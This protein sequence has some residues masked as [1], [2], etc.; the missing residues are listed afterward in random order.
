VGD[1]NIVRQMLIL[2]FSSAT[3]ESD[4][5]EHYLTRQLPILVRNAFETRLPGAVIAAPFATKVGDRRVW[6]VQARS[7]GDDSALAFGSQRGFDF[8]VCGHLEP[9]DDAGVRIL[10][11]H[12]LDTESQSTAVR[13][14]VRGDTLGL[15]R[16]AIEALA[17]LLA[18]GA[19]EAGELFDPGTRS[20]R[21]YECYMQGLDVL[22]TLRSSDMALDD[23]AG[24]LDPFVRALE[25]D[26]DFADALTAGMSCALQAT[27]PEGKSLSFERIVAA[28]ARWVDCYP[29][30]SRIYAVWAELLIHRRLLTEALGVLERSHVRLSPVPRELVRRA[31]D[32]LVDLARHGE[33]LEIYR[34]CEEMQ[35]DKLVRERMATLC[36]ML[37]RADEARVHL[38]RCLVDEPDRT[39]LLT[40]LALMELRAGDERAM[41]AHFARVFRTPMGPSEADLVKLNSVLVQRPAADE[42]RDALRS[43]F[44][45]ASFARSS[46]I[47]LARALRLA[48]ARTESNLCLKSIA[49]DGLAP[50]LRSSLARERLN[51]AYPDFDREFGELAKTVTEGRADVDRQLLERAAAAEPDFWPARFVAAL[52]DARGGRIE[53]AVDRFAEVIELQPKND[54]VWYTRGL[55]LLKLERFV[56]AV[57]HFQRAVA[58]NAADG[59]YHI[60]LALA[61]AH[62]RLPEEARAS[63]ARAVALRPDHPDN[64]RLTRDIE[65]ALRRFAHGAHEEL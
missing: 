40:K 8:V 58:L 20:A 59:D 50:E 23:A 65:R 44:P 28:L 2:P 57:E 19:Q 32:V 6:V 5:S 36:V 21:A 15:G 43:W 47:V 31:G 39:D 42:L 9:T 11:L 18:L 3:A 12:A 4:P 37:Q 56:E 22:L 55:Y 64:A 33:A 29:G 25:T 16:L 1:G 51:F 24:A 53:A 41:W 38:E 27:E 35:H 52:A 7:W 45:P 10:S 14:V 26:P 17:P 48:G 54:I 63:L 49:A 62:L 61:Q 60:H 30:D 13:T 46:R 34:R